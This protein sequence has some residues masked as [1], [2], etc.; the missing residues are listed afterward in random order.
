MNEVKEKIISL[1]GKKNGKI[2]FKELKSKLE[3]DSVSLENMILELKLDGK[4][5]QIG[6]KYQLFP[7]DLLIGE[8]STTLSGNK[9]I[10]YNDRKY[11]LG[12]TELSKAVLLNDVVAFKFSDNDEV[13]VTSI[14]DR[15]IKNI[16]CEVKVIDGVKKIIPYHKNIKISLDK[17]DLKELLDGDIILVD[18]DINEEDEYCNARL[19]KKLNIKDSPNKDE[20]IIG[21]NYGFDNDY[22]DEY[23]EELAKLPKDTSNED[24]SKRIDF[25]NLTTCTI[26]GVYTKDM[27]DAVGAVRMD[28]DI[29]RVYVHI[30]DV[31]HYVKPNSLLFKRACD[32]TTSLYL[33]NS[34]FHMF[35]HIISNGICSLNQGEDRLTKSAIMDIDR[36]GNIVNYEIVKSVINS[37]KKMSYEAVDE[38]LVN[39]KIPQGYKEY[40]DLI[41]LLNEASTRIR[42]RMERNG[43]N[44]FANMELEKKYD[45]DGKLIEYHNMGESPA[46]KL[47]E[48]LMLAANEAVA[49]Y[50]YYSPLPGVYRIHEYPELRKVNE[51]I[52][53]LNELG[54]RIRPVKQVDDPI[55][56]QKVLK[57]LQDDDDYQ[58]LSTIILRFMKRARYSTDNLGHFALALYLYTHF[59]SPIRRLPDLLVSYILDILIDKPELIDTINYDIMKNELEKLCNRSS[60]MSRRADL[61]EHLADKNSI[62]DTMVNDIGKEFEC[63]VLDIGEQLKIRI[64]SIDVII[65][66][67]SFSDHIRYD[68]K[69]K[70]FYDWTNGVHLKVGTKV[71][72]KLIDVNQVN[73]ELKIMVINAIDSRIL[74]KNSAKVRTLK[75]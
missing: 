65:K 61:A 55:V 67:D 66:K 6:N 47:I 36:N 16:T 29:I 45:D 27:D 1:I 17:E 26:D 20:I 12:N 42:A 62:V 23:L 64:N 21:M 75:I 43:M 35:H 24:L 72:V 25:R 57:S 39:G 73:K 71:I 3:I 46:R 28:N 44:S 54:K 60:L 7:D 9:V 40:V 41:L 59:T 34:V 18:I 33:N 51:A 70:L 50:L 30:S 56:I 31:A 8:V 32:K 4:I 14:I 63:V 15:R 58:M 49:N 2:S 37:N 10:F 74:E 22:S 48:F 13:L 11:S 52:A 69:R 19:I 68:K 53:T 5:L 38:I